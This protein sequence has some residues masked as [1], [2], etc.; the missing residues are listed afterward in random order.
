MIAVGLAQEVVLN[1][2]L[3]TSRLS[4]IA[5]TVVDSEG[6]SAAGAMITLRSTRGGQSFTRSGGQVAGDG[7]FTLRNIPPGEHAIDIE[8]RTKAPDRSAEFGSAPVSIAGEDVNGLR[9]TT[10]PGTTVRGTVV[11]EGTAPRTGRTAPLRILAVAARSQAPVMIDP[12]NDNGLVRA[13]GS[14]ELR[15]LAGVMLFRATTPPLWTIKSVTLDGSE[16]TD[17]PMEVRGTKTITGL[18]VVFSDRLTGISGTVIGVRG[19]PLKEYAVVV[20]PVDVKEGM[21]ATRYVRTARSDQD[22]SFQIR[23]LPP[24]RYLVAAV[25]TLEQGRE[26]DP[27]FLKRF[28]DVARTVTLAEGQTLPLSLTVAAV[29]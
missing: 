7:T 23:G 18:R 5:G 12:D 8:L 28:R 4:R 13:D 22:G 11:F 14:F 17:M 29:Q 6:R 9:I 3:L 2:S 24:G 1:F 25:E 15:G 26:W 10:T 20:H 19:A 27:E 21:V 16:I